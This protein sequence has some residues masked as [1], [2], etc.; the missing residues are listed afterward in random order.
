M[1][2]PDFIAMRKAGVRSKRLSG[3][4]SKFWLVHR[5]GLLSRFSFFGCDMCWNRQLQHGR[6]LAFMESGKQHD[7]AVWK[8]ERIMMHV[9]SI[10][11]DPLEPSDHLPNFSFR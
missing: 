10:F 2:D 11:V 9:L 8:F 4:D 5:D 1:P 7:V 6:T 3:I